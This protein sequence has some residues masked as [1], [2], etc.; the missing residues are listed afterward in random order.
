ML[1]IEFV[2][3]IVQTQSETILENFLQEQV[4]RL[5]T[6]SRRSRLKNQI[7]NLCIQLEKSSEGTVIE[8]DAFQNFCKCY[9][10]CDCIF[11]YLQ[12]PEDPISQDEFFQQLL[13]KY[14]GSGAGDGKRTISSKDKKDI[15]HFFE[16]I[17]ACYRESVYELLDDSDLAAVNIVKEHLC[18]LEGQMD[19]MLLVQKEQR[20]EEQAEASESPSAAVFQ[21]KFRKRLF[22]E[23]KDG[24]ALNQVFLWPK[25][26]M[27]GRPEAT[28]ALEIVDAFLRDSAFWLLV[29]EGVAGSG[30]SSF[31]AALSE[32]YHTSQYI[33]KSLRDLTGG[34]TI[35]FRR[36][37]LKE[38]GLTA[39]DMDKI[40]ILDGYDEIHHRVKQPVFLSDLKWFGEHGYKII[41]T[42]RPGY[43]ELSRSSMD[44]YVQIYLRLFDG[45]QIMQW[46]ER[47]M[48]AG[49][50]LF[51]ETFQALTQPG[52][53]SPMHEVWQIP[54]MLYVIANRN[55]NVQT[56]TCM[57][58]L[59]E[60]VFEGMK[61]DKA[62]LT[63]EILERHYLIAQ[64]IAYCMD[65]EGLLTVSSDMVREWCGELFD[66]TFFSS[67][68]IE[69][70][71]IE[72]AWM[73]EFV[74]K[75]ILEF[76]AAKWIFRQLQ[77]DRVLEALGDSY[78]SDEVLEYLE[79]FMK[80]KH[81]LRGDV[82]QC[83]RQA[84]N[85]FAETGIYTD[86]VL[87]AE[88]AEA[89]YDVLFCNLS[90]LTKFVLK[91]RIIG[92]TLDPGE[93]G[94]TLSFLIRN[95]LHSG[96]AKPQTARWI[97]QNEDLSGLYMPTHL[98]FT[99][100][101]LNGVSFLD[102]ALSRVDFFEC[103]LR[104]AFF[105]T[106][107]FC[108]CDFGAANLE[109]A[110]FRDVVF[111]QVSLYGIRFSGAKLHQLEMP[112]GFLEIKSFGYAHLSEVCFFYNT[113]KKLLFEG[114]DLKKVVFDH[115][116]LNRCSFKKTLWNQVEF[117]YVTLK[118]CD[119]SEVDAKNSCFKNCSID[120]KTRNTNPHIFRNI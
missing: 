39:D 56:V 109:N 108:R 5:Q 48:Q 28:E 45:E 92:E 85:D 18:V 72:G 35:D 101:N 98:G 105:K 15:F 49:G 57:G 19:Q 89:K 30:K 46:L 55:I 67:V 8:T 51:S 33:Y 104:N 88:M 9:H 71:I 76:F 3:A 66:E 102:C 20:N 90:V 107:T 2:K 32:L 36:E 40:L 116:Y 93:H 114:S 110:C 14:A 7:Q 82:R 43:L 47:Y 53:H 96:F 52:P 73:L 34:D 59:Y 86:G 16:V 80:S 81:M 6:F 26:H 27:A 50:R 87:P 22:L 42:T 84:F 38:C 23:E 31:A 63:A 21:R 120:V 69:N 44:A 61:R 58:E 54:I 11:H 106:V 115:C 41:L 111:D 25:C 17:L 74:H 97:F 113:L 100:Q 24:P 117:R 70:S 13:E 29:V 37:L 119:F 12:H 79:Y 1:V 94:K 91:E 112:T 75:S 77:G 60:Q 99:G 103:N 4:G 62:G 64:R 83:V 10:V 118:D 68:Y 65:R 78:I 95:Y